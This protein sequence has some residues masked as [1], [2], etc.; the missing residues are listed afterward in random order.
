MIA[1]Y[2]AYI[3]DSVSDFLQTPL[4]AIK[5]HMATLCTQSY[6]DLVDGNPVEAID[7]KDLRGLHNFQTLPN[8][9]R[10][11]GGQSIVPV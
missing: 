11:F 7:I 1:Q 8:H 9:R 4:R 2:E 10:L 6:Y 5:L 3:M